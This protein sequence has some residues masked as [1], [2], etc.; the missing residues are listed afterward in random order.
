MSA[1]HVATEVRRSCL[2]GTASKGTLGR[3]VVAEPS[4]SW[5]ANRLVCLQD[6]FRVPSEQSR[7]Q[8]GARNAPR[9]TPEGFSPASTDVEGGE[10]LARVC[11][12]NVTSGL[13]DWCARRRSLSDPAFELLTC[14]LLALSSDPK[15]SVAPRCLL[16]GLRLLSPPRG[17]SGPSFPDTCPRPWCCPAGPPATAETHARSFLRGRAIPLRDVRTAALATAQVS[18]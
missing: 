12:Q 16:N 18:V 11:G 15:P 7:F 10:S 2:R 3:R 6:T 17:G 5:V 14:A 1:F 9:G 13:L 4:K 8:C